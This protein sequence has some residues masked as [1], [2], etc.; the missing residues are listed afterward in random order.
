MRPADTEE[1]GLAAAP[2]I[3]IDFP[4]DGGLIEVTSKPEALAERSA[5]AID[6][7]MDTIHDFAD[8]VQYTINGLLV[9]PKEVDVEFGIKLDAEVGALIAKTR[10]EAHIV[11]TLRWDTGGGQT[12]NSTD[13]P[14][15][16]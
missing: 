15:A 10:M 13:T 12:G 14:A 11:V 4:S 9:R 7:A 3:L 6:A 8:R 16:S 1:P 5:S 2:K